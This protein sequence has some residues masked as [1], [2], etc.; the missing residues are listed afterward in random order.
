MRLIGRLLPRSSPRVIIA[1]NQLPEFGEVEKRIG[2]ARAGDCTPA[3]TAPI[4]TAEYT[5][6]AYFC[7]TGRFLITTSRY[8]PGTIMLPS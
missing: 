4:V 7:A 8:S 2:D 1:P 5:P 3:R 6:S